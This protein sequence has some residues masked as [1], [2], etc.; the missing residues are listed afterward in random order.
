MLHDQLSVAVDTS[1]LFDPGVR[2]FGMEMTV[3]FAMDR[4]EVWLSTSILL[5]VSVGVSDFSGS[6]SVRLIFLPVI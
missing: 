3:G 4:G 6:S 2:S 5:L 1:S